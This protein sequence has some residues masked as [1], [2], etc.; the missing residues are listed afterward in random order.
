M[1]LHLSLSKTASFLSWLNLIIWNYCQRW[2]SIESSMILTNENKN[3]VICFAFRSIF[4]T[5]ATSHKVWPAMVQ[6][7]TVI[8]AMVKCRRF[9][10]W[11]ISKRWPPACG[12]RYCLRMAIL[13]CN[14]LTGSRHPL[15][16]PKGARIPE[17]HLMQML[18]TG[19][20][21][22]QHR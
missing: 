22:W 16:F 5:F 12:N 21:D 6:C 10:A 4:T 3:F 19:K 14:I 17:T 13:F 1:L 9:Q 11:N 8:P 20:M 2:I 7:G 15:G 18:S